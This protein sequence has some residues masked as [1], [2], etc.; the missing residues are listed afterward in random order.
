M[1][2]LK[3]K[4]N[5]LTSSLIINSTLNSIN[6]NKSLSMVYSEARGSTRVRPF[7]LKKIFAYK[8]NKANLDPFHMCFTISL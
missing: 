4:Q 3:H 2:P 8:R 6:V 5:I 1:M 7:C